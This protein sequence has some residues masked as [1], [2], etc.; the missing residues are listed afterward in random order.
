FFI[1]KRDEDKCDPPFLNR[2]EKDHKAYHKDDP[3]DA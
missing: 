2:F 3:F 1:H